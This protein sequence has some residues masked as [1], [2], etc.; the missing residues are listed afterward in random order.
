MKESFRFFPESLDYDLA[1]RAINDEAFGPGRFVRAAM[2]LRERGMHDLDLS[3]LCADGEEIIAS[4]RMTPIIAGTVRGHI[5]G[6]IA[7]RPLYQK[8]GIGRKLVQMAIDAASKNGSEAIILIGDFPYY[9]Q[10]GFKQV[11][12]NNL[13]FPGP[14]DPKRVMFLPLIGDIVENLKGVV[15]CREI[16]QGSKSKGV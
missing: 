1:I 4:V 5:L 13:E 2:L 12:I 9:S 15:R 3:F 8:R 14:V 11:P 7:V 16:Y 6:P 10:F